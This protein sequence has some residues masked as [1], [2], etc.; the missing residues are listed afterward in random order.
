MALPMNSETVVN[1]AAMGLGFL[2]VTSRKPWQKIVGG[3]VGVLG[4]LGL[5]SQLSGSV[6]GTALMVKQM[7]DLSGATVAIQQLN[8]ATVA[9]QQPSMFA[10]VEGL[11]SMGPSLT[12]TYSAGAA[13]HL[14]WAP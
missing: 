8:G 9:I 6:A 10:G 13:P 4:I 5:R 12:S 2:G 14:Y 1:L 11:G 7:N 3:A